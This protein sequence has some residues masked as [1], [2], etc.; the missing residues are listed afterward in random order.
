[1]AKEIRLTWIVLNLQKK[2]AGFIFRFKHQN[3]LSRGSNQNLLQKVLSM[4]C[5]QYFF[6]E[7]YCAGLKLEYG[8][9]GF[10]P[11]KVMLA[12]TI[13]LMT[14]FCKAKTLRC[15]KHYD[16]DLHKK[17]TQFVSLF[18]QIFQIRRVPLNERG[19]HQTRENHKH[20]NKNSQK[21][22]LF[23]LCNFFPTHFNLFAVN[24]FNF[25]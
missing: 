11:I 2:L 6:G 22:I 24:F 9:T 15:A 7:T 13:M 10:E 5:Y 23:L 19:K 18:F 8:I 12:L 25:I 4:K 20:L 3:K 14:G 21:L 17:H 1:M 16:M